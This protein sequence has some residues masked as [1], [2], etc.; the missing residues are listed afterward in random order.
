MATV[1]TLLLMLALNRRMDG[2]QEKFIV[3]GASHNLKPLKSDT[4]PG[5]T[6]PAAPAALDKLSEWLRSKLSG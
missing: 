4:D 3:P 2:V 6:G 5:F 1:D